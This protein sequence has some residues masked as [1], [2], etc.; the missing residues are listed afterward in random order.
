MPLDT[1]ALFGLLFGFLC[2]SR[3][4]I[5]LNV[6]LGLTQELISGVVLT[7]RL[8]SQWRSRTTKQS[9]NCGI[10]QASTQHTLHG[11]YICASLLQCNIL[12]ILT[13]CALS[14]FKWRLA[15]NAFSKLTKVR[16]GFSGLF[17][18][19]CNAFLNGF[20]GQCAS[21]RC[22]AHSLSQTGFSTCGSI[23]CAKNGSAAN[24]KRF[25]S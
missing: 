5:K 15:C 17:W 10:P 22:F 2:L 24:L 19:C 18:Q 25:V 14:A 7:G 23:Q 21:G 8:H 9:A 6:F 16:R 3:T 20:F 13:K 12:T 1:Q 4:L 11:S